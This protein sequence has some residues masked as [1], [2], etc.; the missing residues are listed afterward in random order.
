M[1][2]PKAHKALTLGEAVATGAVT[3]QEAETIKQEAAPAADGES[4]AMA[5]ALAD[6]PTPEP[7]KAAAPVPPA[8]GDEPE[9]V[10]QRRL[11]R[12]TNIVA[13]ADFEG[14]TLLGDIV[15][16]IVDLFKHRPKLWSAML[17]DE[18]KTMIKHVEATAK[19]LLERIVLVVAEE[20]SA[21]IQ[22]TMLSAFNVKGDAIEGKFKIDSVNGELLLQA[23]ALA[24]HKIVIISADDT[25]F[26]GT[27]KPVTPEPDQREIKFADDKPKAADPP[28]HP[29]DDSDLAGDDDEEE[30]NPYAKFG[31]WDVGE[32]EWL[33]ADQEAWSRSKEDAGRWSEEEAGSIA[34]ECDNAIVKLIDAPEAEAQA[35][36]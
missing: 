19:T 2:K 9:A 23:H 35:D 32:A 10:F 14:K 1:T 30:A 8:P 15:V 13:D 26:R 18:Q 11:D 29:D 21:T 6:G 12:L 28:A 25:R 33:T 31:V 36:A 34:D 17:A 16:L 22:A 27:R 20:D 7:A 3:P 5:P 4:A 24:G